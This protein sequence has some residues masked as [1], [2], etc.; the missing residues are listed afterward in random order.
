VAG[1]LQY[2]Q[3]KPIFGF[4]GSCD[5]DLMKAL[6]ST[7]KSSPAPNGSLSARSKPG[8]GWLT[9]ALAVGGIGACVWF[10]RADVRL[11]PG[12]SQRDYQRVSQNLQRSMRRSPDRDEVFFNLGGEFAEQQKWGTAESLFANVSI[13][14]QHGREA[15][16]LQA[17]SVLQQDRLR[18]SE[19]LFREY[20][21]DSPV[22]RQPAWPSP[23]DN[24]DRIQALHFLSYLLSVELRF[25][26]RKQLLS[27]LIRRNDADLFDTLACHFQS[28]MEWN[29]THSV[30][31]LERACK[32]SPTDWQLQAVL[33]Q[34]RIAQGRP[35][36]AWKLL[37]ECREHLPHDL[38]I[39]AV[40]LTCLDERGDQRGYM[41]LATQLPS[42][43]DHD[44]VSLLRHRGQFALRQ[45]RAS[46]AVECFQRALAIDPADVPSRMGRAQAWLVLKQSDR[47]TQE[48]STIQNLARIQNRLGWAASKTPTPEVMLDIIRLSADAGLRTAAADV[49][50]ISIGLFKNPTRF[51]ELLREV[52]GESSAGMTP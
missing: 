45:E 38:A 49:C 21:A 33:A 14:S 22:P 7:I 46:D 6:D 16:Y 17:Q 44:P 26:E 5:Q 24:D 3:R 40:C 27:E 35:D 1:Q 11:P 31:R 36:D 29:N 19:R 42:I 51:E 10:M 41:E 37:L 2:E 50:K 12:V 23:P 25:D 30:D 43:S 32:V 18:E 47:R 48:L 52:T 39:A 9:V 15:R 20:L 34:Y 8:L 28:L 4:R 13:H